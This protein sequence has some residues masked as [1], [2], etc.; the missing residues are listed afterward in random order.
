MHISRPGPALE[1]HRAEMPP[2]TAVV[3]RPTPRRFALRLLDI[4]GSF[5][6]CLCGLFDM[7]K[8]DVYVCTFAGLTQRFVY[9]RGVI[10]CN[11]RGSQIILGF[12]KCLIYF[13]S[14]LLIA[15]YVEVCGWEIID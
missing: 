13:Y 12:F 11:C 8:I 15:E 6:L 10:F 3:S 7:T 1:C 14:D 9:D 4:F 5:W 2:P